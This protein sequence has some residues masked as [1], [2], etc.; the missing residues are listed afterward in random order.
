MPP[1]VLFT[2][3]EVIRAA[4][5]VTRRSGFAGLTA[6]ALAAEL[7]CSPKPIFGLLIKFLY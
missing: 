1:K 7:G 2:R 3:E 5:E 4:V 6:R